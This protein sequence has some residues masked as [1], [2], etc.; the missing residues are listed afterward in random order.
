M[1]SNPNEVVIVEVIVFG[2]DFYHKLCRLVDEE[3]FFKGLTPFA[4]NRPFKLI[5]VQLSVTGGYL[6]PGLFL[7]IRG[8]TVHLSCIFPLQE[9]LNVPFLRNA[10]PI[11]L[12]PAIGLF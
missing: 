7:M 2:I 8:H 11:H 12:K 9:P 6:V 5:K 3:Y 10:Q 1:T 4:L